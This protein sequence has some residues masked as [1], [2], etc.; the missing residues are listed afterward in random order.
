VRWIGPRRVRE[1]I[2]LR[3]ADIHQHGARALRQALARV[4]NVE[5]GSKWSITSLIIMLQAVY[6]PAGA[7]IA[8]M[9]VTETAAPGLY[10]A[11]APALK[12]ARVL[13]ISL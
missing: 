13:F 3:V 5:I 11:V 6:P 8:A 1:G 4:F 12:T 2:A 10:V 9:M 7:Q